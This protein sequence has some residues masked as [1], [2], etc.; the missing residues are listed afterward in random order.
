MNKKKNDFRS[1]AGFAFRHYL[2]TVD[3]MSFE[4]VNVSHCHPA[5]ELYYLVSGDVEYIVSGISYKLKTGDVLCVKAFE[6]HVINVKPTCDYERYVLEFE[7]GIV[8]SIKGVNPISDIFVTKSTAIHI[9]AKV[10][11]NSQILNIFESCDR[12]YLENS[13]YTSHLMLGDA[14]K[15]ISEFRLCFDKAVDLPYQAIQVKAKHQEIINS[16]SSY[17]KANLDKKITIDDIS[18]NVFLSKSYLQHL[19]KQYFGIPVSEY[20]FTQKMHVAQ[21]MLENGAS[22][23]ET[24]SA[25]GYK[26]YSSFCMNYKKYFGISPKSHHSLNA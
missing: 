10:V 4:R 25:L 21:H 24:S 1:N 12:E 22:L 9:P 16:V 14:I 3:E 17:I 26:Y 8:P 2:T 20:I 18:N 11:K 5:Y 19:F 15:L 13:V 6:S 7:M 23:A